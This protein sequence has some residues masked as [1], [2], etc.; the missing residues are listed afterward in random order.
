LIAVRKYKK[1]KHIRSVLL[2]SNNL[3]VPYVAFQ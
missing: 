3:I 2:H 1:E